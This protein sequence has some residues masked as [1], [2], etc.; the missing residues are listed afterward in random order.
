MKKLHQT[1][2]KFWQNRTHRVVVLG[3]LALVTVAVTWGIWSLGLR[4]DTSTT[5]SFQ[6]ESGTKSGVTVISDANAAGGSAVQFSVITDPPTGTLMGW[7]LTAANTGL[8]AHGLTCAGLQLYTGNTKP[9][10]G[11][12]ISQKRIVDQLDLSNGDIII[13]KSCI[14]PTTV[15]AGLPM[16]NTTNNNVCNSSGCAP[17][18]GPVT[19]RDSEFDGSQL[20]AYQ[21]AF[22]GPLTGIATLQRNYVHDVGSGFALMNTGKQFSSIVE[23]NYITKLRAYGDGATTGNHSDGFTIRDFDAS[24]N[25]TRTVVVRNNRFDCSSGNDTGAF[26][27]QTYAGNIQNVTVSGNLLEGGGYTLGLNEAFGNSYS[28]VV[29]INNRFSPTGWGAAYVQGGAGW[30]Q[31]TENYR[32]DPTKP[33]N[34]GTVISKP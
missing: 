14:Q 6:A 16:L 19:V 11:T 18:S 31:W 21:A 9:A 26:F 7:Q 13:E 15:S 23:G 27:I 12:V 4:A 30:N 3:G 20:T 29:A 22:T 24:Q 5:A 33:D 10:A 25:T 1:S 32:N 34:K 8:A 2:K 28:N 17:A